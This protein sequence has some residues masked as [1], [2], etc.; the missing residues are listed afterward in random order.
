VH[1]YH[2]YMSNNVDF[3]QTRSEILMFTSNLED[4]DQYELIRLHN[5]CCAAI[6]TH[7]ENNNKKE[8]IYIICFSSCG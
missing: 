3:D 4:I 2:P 5:P 7:R 8:R 6:V 1:Q